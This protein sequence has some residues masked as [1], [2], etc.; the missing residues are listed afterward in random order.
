VVTH[1]LAPLAAVAVALVVM[2]RVEARLSAQTSELSALRREVALLGAHA[3]NGASPPVIAASACEGLDRQGVDA[4]ARAV[5]AAEHE[6]A[7][8][9]AASSAA[10][11]AAPPQRTSEQEKRA[12]EAGEIATRAIEVGRLTRDD[13]QR[14]RQDFTQGL[15]T[16]DERNAVRGPDRRRDQRA[17]TGA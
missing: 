16:P 8:A 10:T 12:A 4:I 15:A 6:H 2:F 13:V 11:A 7:Q 17:K 1:A 5:V 14:I 3:P 9:A